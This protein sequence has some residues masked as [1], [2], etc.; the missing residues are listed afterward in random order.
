VVADERGTVAFLDGPAGPPLGVGRQDCEVQPVVLP[1]HSLLVTYTD[2]LIET[3]G[4]DFDQG[5]R[6]LA[7]ALRHPGR[8]R[9]QICDDLLAH[10]VPDAADDDVS[11]LLTRTLPR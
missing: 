2:G 9:D 8:P 5:M 11:V 3:R 10:V 6:R 4:T 1:P 7:Q